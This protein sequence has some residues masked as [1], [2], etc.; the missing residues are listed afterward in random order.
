MNQIERRLDW[1]RLL[2]SVRQR[3]SS[4]VAVS[5]SRNEFE[6]DYHRIVGS[7][8][9]RRLQDKTQVFPLDQ[10]DF[11]RTRLT[12][13]LEV[14]SLARSLSQTVAQEI[15]FRGLDPSLTRELTHEMG[16]LLLC[17]GLIHDIG[18][19]P[20]GHYGE[21]SIR[22][23]FKINLPL[24]RYRGKRLN[25]VLHPQM[26]QDLLN[27][28]GNAQA[29]R[30][31]SKLHFLKDDFGMNLTLPLL[32]TI[33]KYP[34]SSLEMKPHH[35]DVRYKKFGYFYTETKLYTEIC[36]HTGT[37]G[38]RHPLTFLLEAADDIAYRTADIEDAY[39]KGRF[40]YGQLMEALMSTPRLDVMSHN[41]QA[42]Y[43]YRCDIL[44]QKR[45]EAKDKKVN[46]PDLYAIQN[47][48][49][50]V[51]ASLIQEATRSFC[52][53]YDAIMNGEWSSDLFKGTTAEYLIGVLGDIAVE[54]VFTSKQI[55]S[56]E[57]AANSIIKGLL[58]KFLPAAIHWKTEQPRTSLEPRMMA[59]ISDNYR[60]S[61]FS[62]SEGKSE[63]EQLYMRILLVTDYIC[64][65]TDNF[66]KSLYRKF[67]GME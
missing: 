4:G 34:V 25:E 55:I 12:H 29:I 54:F 57:I 51:Q 66:A 21:T 46:K 20:F 5:D 63:I 45:A 14:S 67:Y 65:M 37:N 49:V 8:S 43:L 50:F 61:Y 44:D 22:D 24:L 60:S 28:E 6:K 64:G 62:Q 35:A 23:W 1:N 48:I 30:L 17:A 39:I 13:S 38:C 27:F 16:D 58:D 7:A 42:D 33:I 11:I 18:N 9:F 32:N 10:S 53:H 3:P 2:T 40:T 19:P 15:Y 52:D 31:L 36:S 41:E 59:M 26:I 56:L 47:W